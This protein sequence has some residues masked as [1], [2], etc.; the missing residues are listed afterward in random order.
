MYAIRS[1]YEYFFTED[2][3]LR[4]DARYVADL[5]SDRRFDQSPGSDDLDNNLIAMAGLTW[6][7]GG[8]PPAPAPPADSDMDGVP[9][10]RDKCPGTPLV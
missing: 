9:D 3:A 2:L 1:Y 8:P 4:V 5:H 6:Q 10:S 7:F